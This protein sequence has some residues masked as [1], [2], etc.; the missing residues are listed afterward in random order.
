MPPEAL[1]GI[2]HGHKHLGYLLVIIPLIQVLL[3]FAGGAKKPG[4]AKVVGLLARWSYR[5]LGGLVML[6]GLALWYSLGYSLFSGFIW[7][8]LLLWG[9]I[10][11]AS[12]RMVLP[13][14]QAVIDG[15]EA[16]NKMLIGSAVQLLCLVVIVG[17]MTVKPF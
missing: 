12:K 2:M 7:I 10:E 4:L 17:L 6:L 11:V 8:A 9:P 13:Q 5:V 1:T 14:V 3:V 16:S 15:G